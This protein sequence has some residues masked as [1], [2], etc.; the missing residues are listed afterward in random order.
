MRC[1]DMAAD[2]VCRICGDG[3]DNIAKSI[4]S[5]QHH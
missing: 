5:L 2:I 3:G 1:N 4:S